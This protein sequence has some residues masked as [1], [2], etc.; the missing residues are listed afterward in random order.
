[1]GPLE[2]STPMNN[3]LEV[4]LAARRWAQ[5]VRERLENVSVL[6]RGNDR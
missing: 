5:R 6:S 1:M 4:E 2:E 3:A